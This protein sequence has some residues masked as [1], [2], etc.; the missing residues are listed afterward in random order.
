MHKYEN[1]HFPISKDEETVWATA[2]ECLARFE[3]ANNFADV[4]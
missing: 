1:T 3:N 4:Y 2:C